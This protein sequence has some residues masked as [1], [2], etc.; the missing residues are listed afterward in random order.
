MW[1]KILALATLLS[2]A[3]CFAMEVNTA[4]EAELDSINGIGPAMSGKIL[5]ERQ[6]GNFKDWPDL[7]ARVKGVRD[8]NAA[9]FSNQGLT[10]NDAAF[11]GATAAPT[12]KK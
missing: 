9:K 5:A 1:Q 10:V 11:I 7:M 2:A 12:G 4:T 3:A 6:K 8:K